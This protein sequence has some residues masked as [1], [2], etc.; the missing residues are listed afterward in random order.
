MKDSFDGRE[1]SVFREKL[2]T[3]ERLAL[4]GGIGGNYALTTWF[5]RA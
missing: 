3:F 1:V 5:P 2:L 4:L